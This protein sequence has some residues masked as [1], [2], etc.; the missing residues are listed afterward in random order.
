MGLPV[1]GVLRDNAAVIRLVTNGVP[2]FA[3][4]LVGSSLTMSWPCCPVFLPEE[5]PAETGTRVVNNEESTHVLQETLV[6]H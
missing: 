3:P 5:L 1:R 4:C 2:G 6:R